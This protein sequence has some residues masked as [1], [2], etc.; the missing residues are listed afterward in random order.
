M[1]NELKD[2]IIQLSEAVTG[3]EQRLV[4]LENSK[5]EKEVINKD[6]IPVG[7]HIFNELKDIGLVELIAKQRN[8]QVHRIG[9]TQ[10]VDGRKFKSLSAAA[11]AFSGI[12]RKSGWV[13]WR[14]ENGKTLK[15]LFKA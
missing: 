6:G 1:E 4:A 3:L 14:D 13:F 12:Q 9:N 15:D 8:Y 7:M 2:T 10:I 5:A 11:E